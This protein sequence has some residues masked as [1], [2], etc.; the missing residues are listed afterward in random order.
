MTVTTAERRRRL[1]WV[2]QGAALLSL[3]LLLVGAL[4][5]RQ[6]GLDLV[7]LLFFHPVVL[8]S[9]ALAA[10]IAALSVAATDRTTRATVPAG[11]LAT[12]CG[13]ALPTALVLAFFVRDGDPL[14]RE[15]APGRN[16]RVVEVG[17]V[18]L[19]PDPKHH[20]VLHTGAG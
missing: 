6:G 16:D 18:G 3:L 11:I 7:K 10:A 5:C 1:P 15:S 19:T 2:L 9:V 20:I 13:L 12:L 8:P 4:A 17:N 14:G